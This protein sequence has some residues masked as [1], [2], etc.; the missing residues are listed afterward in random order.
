M[1]L[2]DDRELVLYGTNDP[3]KVNNKEIFVSEYNLAPNPAKRS[4]VIV[5]EDLKLNDVLST[6]ECGVSNDEK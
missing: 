5:I 4:A 2:H 6:L 1:M 3:I